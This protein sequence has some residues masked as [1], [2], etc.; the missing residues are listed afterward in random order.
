MNPIINPWW[1]Y[2]MHIADNVIVLLM[3]ASIVLGIIAICAAVWGGVV[4][5]DAYEDEDE[6]KKG[7]S[8]TRIAVRFTVV[9]VILAGV[10]ILIPPSTTQTKMLIASYSTPDNIETV[11]TQITEAAKQIAS[12]IK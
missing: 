8:L 11:I 6:I 9:A 5:Y 1:F 12:S 7:K 2:W 10:S 4:L 3:L